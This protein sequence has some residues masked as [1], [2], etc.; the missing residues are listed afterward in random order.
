MGERVEREKRKR[1][2]RGF[3]LMAYPRRKLTTAAGLKAGRG[4]GGSV[5]RADLTA[6]ACAGLGATLCD[7]A[8]TRARGGRG[9][10]LEGATA[11]GVQGQ[12]HAG[13]HA[14]RGSDT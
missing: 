4:G 2:G 14:A 10:G 11:R 5:R 6:A 12:G 13:H 8:G 3:R 9:A 1:R 7:G